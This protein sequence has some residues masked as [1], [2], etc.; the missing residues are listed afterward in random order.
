M[1]LRHILL[2]SVAEFL[3]YVYLSVPSPLPPGHLRR[4][5]GVAVVG[6]REGV[7]NTKNHVSGAAFVSKLAWNKL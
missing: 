1:C 2:N 6:E 3:F 7:T 5:S 4:R